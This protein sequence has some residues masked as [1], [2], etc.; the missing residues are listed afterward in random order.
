MSR[1]ALHDF[2]HAV[3]HSAALRRDCHLVENTEELIA[4]A[5]RYGF[6]ISA[7]DL[8]EDERSVAMEAWF[9]A[10][11]IQRQRSSTAR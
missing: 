5:R 7:K 8:D 6:A 2:V 1:Q 9:H 10:S 4:L 3:E 11:W